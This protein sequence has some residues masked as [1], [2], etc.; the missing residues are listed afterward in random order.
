MGS[1]VEVRDKQCCTLE[2]SR[3]D[4]PHELRLLDFLCLQPDGLAVD[5]DAL[6]L[7]R[8][9][10]PPLSNLGGELHDDLLLAT[11]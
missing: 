1:G 11:L 2:Y 10:L 7:V 6:S 5:E 9:R 3:L 8:L 4:N